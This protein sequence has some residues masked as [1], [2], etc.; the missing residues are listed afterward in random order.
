M[1]DT[2]QSGH[3]ADIP[4]GEASELVAR[5]RVIEAQPLETRAEARNELARLAFGDLGN[6]AGLLGVAHRL[7]I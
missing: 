3:V 5:L 4:E 7:R 1:S 2:E 6:G